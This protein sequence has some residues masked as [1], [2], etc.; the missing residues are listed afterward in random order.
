VL[1]EEAFRRIAER[2]PGLSLAELQVVIHLAS[3]ADAAWVAVI[4]GRDL[5]AAVN[6]GH[7]AVVYAL[8]SLRRAGVISTELGSGVR[9]ARHTLLFL[10]GATGSKSEPLGPTQLVLSSNHSGSKIEPLAAATGSK[11]EPVRDRESAACGDRSKE[12]APAPASID[13]DSSKAAVIDRLYK[14]RISDFDAGDVGIARGWIAEYSRLCGW[15]NRRPPDDVMVARFLS[16]APLASLL[17]LLQRMLREFRAG[18]GALRAGDSDGW[19]VAVAVQRLHGISAEEQRELLSRKAASVRTR[20]AAAG[21]DVGELA[22]GK[23]M[24][25]GGR[26]RSGGA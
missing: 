17:E 19:F 21:V 23:A 2:A 24:F 5:A 11:S 9:P 13:S 26:K 15:Q 10:R 1:L 12:R 3:I 8:D 16:V 14:A 6:L 7:P 20:G 18:R 22:R 4:S 25:A